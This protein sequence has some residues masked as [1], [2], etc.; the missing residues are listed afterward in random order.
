[1]FRLLWCIIFTLVPL[2]ALAGELVK[3]PTR[4]EARTN[5]F[6]HASPGAT[7]TLLIFP[8]G[9]GGFGRVEDGWPGSSNFL[10]RTAKLWAAEGY[11]LVIFG[12]PSDSDDLGYE[13]RIAGPHLQDVKAV[14]EWV[15][16]QSPAPIWVLGTSRGTISAAATLINLPDAQIAGGVFSASVVNFKKTG[17]LPKQDLS[18]ISVPVL[19]YH[20]QADA[21][22]QC[23][24][25]E[26]PAIIS[27]LKNA[28]VKK[29]MMVSGGANP[30]GNVC[31]AQHWHGFI[32][33][34]AQAV[35]DISAWIKKPVN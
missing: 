11:N 9:G 12:K 4:P 32:G 3:V 23:R 1:M 10:V 30:T 18:K 24:P 14:L 33:M 26:V 6:W 13:D 20:H 8:G 17:A 34:E 28:P 27:G 21:C 2:I 15:K 22:E 35:A 19:V 31:E 5:V 16:A 29:L 7:A 25:H